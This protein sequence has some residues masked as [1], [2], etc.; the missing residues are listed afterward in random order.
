MFHVKTKNIKLFL[1]KCYSGKAA[2]QKLK[3]EH[4]NFKQKLSVYVG[5]ILSR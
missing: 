3:A 5:V 1:Q 4:V 2:L